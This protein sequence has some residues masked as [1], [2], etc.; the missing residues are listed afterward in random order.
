VTGDTVSRLVG[1]P[2]WVGSLH[3]GVVDDVILGADLAIVLGVVVETRAQRHCFLP[4]ISA[5]R[6][7]DGAL[8]A[9]TTATLVGEIE[10]DQFLRSG[11]RLSRVLGLALDDPSDGAGV[12]GDLVI[13]PGG[14]IEGF[15]VSSALG[16]RSIALE[17]TRVRWS[18]GELLELSVGEPEEH[19]KR[20]LAAMRNAHV[21]SF[22]E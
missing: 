22:A 14:R 11:T 13:A 9:S 20:E 5:R 19:P 10:L 15:V 1:S 8:E 4:W 2:V 16:K 12:V 6:R 7:P 3:I 21:P 18:E 17:D